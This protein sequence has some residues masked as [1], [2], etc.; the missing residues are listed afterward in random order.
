M[1]LASWKELQQWVQDQRG[2]IVVIDVWSTYCA[3]CIREFPHFIALSERYRSQVA[4]AS[5][6]VDFYGGEDNNPES[7]RPQ[8]LKFLKS[9]NA[10]SANFIATD[11][12]TEV[13]N[14]ISTSA[15]P[16]AIVYD[17]EGKL[18]KIFNNDTDEYGADGFSYDEQIEPLV[19]SLTATEL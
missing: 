14:Q 2:K 10:T 7:V 13:L 12:D 9:Q 15:I 3:T 11:P 5:L 16:A 19:Q 6:S 17:K 18:Q 4:C 1:Q 8:V